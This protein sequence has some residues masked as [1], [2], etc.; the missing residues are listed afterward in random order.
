[1]RLI[2][3]HKEAPIEVKLVL[4]SFIGQV[5]VQRSDVV[6]DILWVE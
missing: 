3:E 2:G 4:E 1:M 5:L 6:S